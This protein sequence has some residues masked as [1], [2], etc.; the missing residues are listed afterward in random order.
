MEDLLSA[1]VREDGRDIRRRGLLFG[2][3]EAGWGFERLRF[4]KG[5]MRRPLFLKKKKKRKQVSYCTGRKRPYR[6]L[7]PYFLLDCWLASAVFTSWSFLSDASSLSSPSL[8]LSL[9]PLSD[10][11]S[12]PDSELDDSSASRSAFGAGELLAELSSL[13]DPDDDSST[14]RFAG[15]AGDELG[16]LSPLSD[17]EEDWASFLATAIMRLRC[18]V[19][20]VAVVG[21]DQ[22]VKKKVSA[23]PSSSKLRRVWSV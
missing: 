14:S 10:P 5:D 18:A 17:E 2:G 13:S 6:R 4:D 3:L 22:E 12:L 20:S 19:R 21:A 1:E 8:S 9:L 11:D 15:G 7:D 16:E 23:T